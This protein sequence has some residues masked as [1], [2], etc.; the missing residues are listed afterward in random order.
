VPP[1]L[2][3]VVISALAGHGV[4][5]VLLPAVVLVAVGVDP[6]HAFGSCGLAAMF[7][8]LLASMTWSWQLGLLLVLMPALAGLSELRLVLMQALDSPVPAALVLAG[9]NALAW[10]RWLRPG[11]ATAGDPAAGPVA[12]VLHQPGIAIA[13]SNADPLSRWLD[14]TR[15]S[16]RATTPRR[17]LRVALGRPFH[18]FGASGAAREVATHAGVIAAWA[19]IASSGQ[20]TIAVFSCAMLA[21]LAAA[22]SI[23]LFALRSR[24]SGELA[25]LP[26]LPGLPAARPPGESA[27]V[28]L[29]TQVRSVGLA[30]VMYGGFLFWSGGN[31]ATIMLLPV[32]AGC[33]IVIGHVSALWVASGGSA[34]LPVSAGIALAVL[35]FSSNIVLGKAGA[36]TGH[37]IWL[38]WLAVGIVSLVLV[39]PAR[40]RLERL[41]HPFLVK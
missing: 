8:L 3:V 9:V 38:A 31:P 19:L 39:R 15:S 35:M 29:R 17:R 34:V 5:S 41:P 24:P 18:L 27:S 25:E 2:R 26:L 11:N 16:T 33:A 37:G 6:L 32:L 30:L 28:V 12:L 22:P 21:A 14:A 4:I 36:A 40:R 10:T 7:G 13:A 20:L 1:R 23:R